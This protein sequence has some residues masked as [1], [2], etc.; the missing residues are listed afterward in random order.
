MITPPVTQNESIEL[1]VVVS[2]GTNSITKIIPMIINN[3]TLVVKA[4]GD[5]LAQGS[6]RTH[7]HV[8][9]IATANIPVLNP[10]TYHWSE[11]SGSNMPIINADSDNPEISLPGGSGTY[12]FKVEATDTIGNTAEDT[13]S[14][15]AL[16]DL[17]ANAGKDFLA[18]EDNNVSLHGLSTGVFGSA[19]I[20]WT[21]LTGKIVPLKDAGTMNPTF[22]A[23][24]L[25]TAKSEVFTF[26]LAVTDDKGRVQKDTVNVTITPNL[27]TV[28]LN[29]VTSMPVS[30]KSSGLCNATGGYAPFTFMWSVAPG[31]DA[32]LSGQVDV[33]PDSMID[34][35]ALSS[36]N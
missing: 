34:I 36:A 25:G 24:V 28:S 5:V 11:T 33:S 15:T 13:V 32:S 9:P 23:P 3:V 2:D 31:T 17:H 10:I 30:S 19:Q 6:H 4:S 18:V 1:Q 14:I 35:D 29:G 21:Q 26:E 12:T 16:D 7:L 22:K 27:P 20:V 8:T